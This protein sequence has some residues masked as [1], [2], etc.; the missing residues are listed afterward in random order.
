VFSSISDERR[1]VVRR[2]VGFRVFLCDGAIFILSLFRRHNSPPWREKLL[3]ELAQAAARKF[4]KI[5][6]DAAHKQTD[7]ALARACNNP[8]TRRRGGKEA[9]RRNPLPPLRR[10]WQKV[11]RIS[12]RKGKGWRVFRRIRRSG[13]IPRLVVVHAFVFN[14]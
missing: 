4:A 6:V 3:L 9:K 12:R 11:E 7:R 14:G 1:R 8:L 5:F 2:S 13:R 10:K